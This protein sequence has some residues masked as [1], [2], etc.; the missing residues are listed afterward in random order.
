MK[1]KISIVEVLK[2]DIIVDSEN[3]QKAKEQIESEYKNG[4]HILNE[5]DLFRVDFLS[6]G[7][8][9]KE[10]NVLTQINNFCEEC[11]EKENCVEDECV[12]FRIENII[13]G[14]KQ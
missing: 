1:Y 4:K 6:N 8:S 3:E 2:K 5:T 10:N 9:E 11:S 12:L 14:E 7:L 13:L